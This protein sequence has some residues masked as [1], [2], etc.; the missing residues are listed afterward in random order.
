[1]I[2]LIKDPYDI[3]MLSIVSTYQLSWRWWTA[4]GLTCYGATLSKILTRLMQLNILSIILYGIAT[5]FVKGSILALYHVIF[6]LTGFRIYVWVLGI[7]NVL[8]T[9]AI[10]LVTMLQ[11]QPLETLWNPTI[12]GGHCIDF[13]NFSLFN[14]AYNFVLD[15]LILLAPMPLVKNLNLSRRKKILLG[16]NFALGGG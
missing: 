13:S 3:R 15:I 5:A 8:G 7:I 9:I 12:Q 1:M 6:P 2:I 14:V 16:L 10:I 4:W 11:C